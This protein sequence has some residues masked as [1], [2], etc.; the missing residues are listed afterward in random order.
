MLGRYCQSDPIG[1][2]GGINTYLYVAANPLSFSDPLGLF[3][4][5][6]PPPRTVPLPPAVEA[7]VVC[8]EN[9]LG[10]QLVITGGAEQTGHSKGSSTTRAKLST[11]GSIATP[12]SN[13][14]A[15]SST[16]ALFNAVS[17]TVRRK[18]AEDLTTTCRPFPASVFLGSR[19]MRV[20]ANHRCSKWKIVI[21]LS[22]L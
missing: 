21:S 8:L 22:C 15:R 18:A 16:V 17:A 7:K 11:L 19:G 10:T 12:A 1:L 13:R 20:C 2:A 3:K 6:A 5:N 4:Y 14:V 9:C